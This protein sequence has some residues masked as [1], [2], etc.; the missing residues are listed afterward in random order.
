VNWSHAEEICKY[1]TNKQHGP[2][3]NF[4]GEKKTCMVGL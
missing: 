4:S 2:I 3:I 1:N